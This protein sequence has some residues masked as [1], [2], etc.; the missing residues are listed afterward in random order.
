M[1]LMG[2]DAL[3]YQREKKPTIGQQQQAQP[4][5]QKPLLGQQMPQASQQALLGQQPQADQQRQ[6][7]G[8]Q[9][10]TLG[11]VQSASFRNQVPA[12]AQ[13]PVP[14]SID[15]MQRASF[16]RAPAGSPAPAPIGAMA[17]PANPN[18]APGSIG[19]AQLASFQQG[20]RQAPVRHPMPIQR[21]PNYAPGSMGAAQLAAFQPR[22]Q[23]MA[24]PY[25]RQALAAR[26]RQLQ[27]RR[28]NWSPY[29]LR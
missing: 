9:P 18:Y 13:A 16:Q 22:P 10:Q 28:P 14:G 29:G 12:Q 19:A 20:P 5:A 25:N 2:L 3:Q 1:P 15:A 24:N 26:A 17:R 8:Q 11:A 23:P 21:A 6:M 4:Q 27:A 7:F